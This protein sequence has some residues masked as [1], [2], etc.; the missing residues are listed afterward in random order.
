MVHIEVMMEGRRMKTARPRMRTR[1][2]SEIHGQRRVDEFMVAAFSRFS[3]MQFLYHFA[4]SSWSRGSRIRCFFRLCQISMLKLYKDAQA[5]PIPS[6]ICD[7]SYRDITT[8]MEPKKDPSASLHP[9]L[10]TPSGRSCT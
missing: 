7:S 5:Y 8:F 6:E 2:V 10:R 1:L 4:S 3:I 9:T